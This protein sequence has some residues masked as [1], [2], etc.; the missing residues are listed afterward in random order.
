[1]PGILLVS[2]GKRADVVIDYE[3]SDFEP[4]V[5]CDQEYG[6]WYWRAS[7]F[8]SKDV[9][10]VQAVGENAKLGPAPLT[11]FLGRYERLCHDAS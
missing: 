1:M 5:D 6:N 7:F 9:F 4:C 8:D 11:T 10:L 3:Q 2:D